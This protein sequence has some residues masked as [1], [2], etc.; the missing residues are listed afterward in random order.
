[1]SLIIKIVNFTIDTRLLECK[2]I[3]YQKE[4]EKGI[5]KPQEIIKEYESLSWTQKNLSRGCGIKYHKYCVAKEFLE[6]QNK[7][8]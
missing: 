6:N 3:Q 4:F 5:S 8:N 2:I 7:I 1:M